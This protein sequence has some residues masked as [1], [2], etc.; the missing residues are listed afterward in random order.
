MRQKGILFALG[1][2]ILWGLFP[3]YWKQ[4]VGIPASQLI[5]H[6]IVWSFVLLFL[7]ILA[8]GQVRALAEHFFE[9]KS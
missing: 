3:I 4:L 6:R 5:G 9:G 1:A 8:R 7:F 2:Y